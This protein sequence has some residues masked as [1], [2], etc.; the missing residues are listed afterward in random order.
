MWIAPS[1][2]WPGNAT[3]LEASITDY[4]N[5]VK[6]S[7]QPCEAPKSKPISYCCSRC[8]RFLLCNGTAAGA[9][10]SA[11]MPFEGGPCLALFAPLPRPPIPPGVAATC[12]LPPASCE[13]PPPPP[14]CLRSFLRADAGHQSPVLGAHRGLY[15]RRELMPVRVAV[16]WRGTEDEHARHPLAGV[17]QSGESG[18]TPKSQDPKVNLVVRCAFS[19]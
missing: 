19:S 10:E 3:T 6:S 16:G 17:R 15:S 8:E 14:A 2:E 12:H 13:P 9:S 5:K 1:S 11:A 7:F 18:P 4:L